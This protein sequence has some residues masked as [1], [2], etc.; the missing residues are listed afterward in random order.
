MDRTDQLARAGLLRRPRRLEWSDKEGMEQERRGFPGGSVGKN[1]RANTGGEVSVPGSGRSPGEGNGNP[2]SFLAWRIPRTE[3]A[4][5]LQSMG[6]QRVGHNLATEHKQGRRD[7]TVTQDP[8]TVGRK[9]FA[10]TS[11]GMG[12]PCG[13]LSRKMTQLDLFY[14]RCMLIYLF[15]N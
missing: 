6:S 15:Q 7:Q 3:E 11:D 8:V 1:L 9:D 10:F 12:G 13:V 2:T 14:L 4:G 5:R